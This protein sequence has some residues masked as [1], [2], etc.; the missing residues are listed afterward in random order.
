MAKGSESYRVLA[1]KYRPQSFED[2]VGQKHVTQT[3]ANAIAVDR[4]AH[5]YLF[6]G[7]RGVGKTT[8]ARIL[9][10]ALNCEKGPTAT[11]CNVCTPC[12]DITG[13][14]S[15]DVLEIDGASNR[16]INEVRELRENV[17]YA[18]SGMRYKVYIIDEVHMLTTEAFN[19][20]LKTLEEPP[21]H[22]IFVFA[23][24]EPF[25]VPGTILS[26]CQRFDFARIPAREITARLTEV[27]ARENRAIDELNKSAGE[28]TSHVEVTPEALA[29][30]ARRAAGGLRDALSLMDQ[31]ISAVDGPVDRAV[32][33]RT[34]GLVGSDFCFVLG[35]LLAAADA[36]GALRL[37]DEVYAKGADLGEVAESLT[38][39]LRDLLMLRIDPGLAAILDIPESEIPRYRAQAERF[40]RETLVELVDRAAETAVSL[41]RSDH[42]RLALELALAEM[43]QSAARVP[44]AEIARR[45]V[46]LEARLGGEAPASSPAVPRSTPAKTADAGPVARAAGT[47]PAPQAT[48]VPAAGGVWEAFLDALRP[49]SIR[50]WGTMHSTEFVGADADGALRVKAGSGAGLLTQVLR[51]PETQSLFREILSGLGVKTPEVRIEGAAKPVAAKPVEKPAAPK[52]VE[53]PAAPKAASK[54]AAKESAPPATEEPVTPAAKPEPPPAAKDTRSMGQLFN[55]EPMLQKALDM[56]DGEVLP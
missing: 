52:P 7:P 42:P 35:D 47:V 31:I 40:A 6:C 41:R 1:L 23:T 2:V 8:A 15:L 21:K 30:V 37:L 45:L 56:F 12:L 25:K 9:A 33:E 34:L 32:V 3:L 36:A 4:V 54:P 44:L 13:G 20:L 51:D 28:K 22:V 26:R 10:K 24:T 19:A 18:P 39:H 46:D 38:S 16:G 53:K 48:N 50:L 49:R 43:A 27:I 5:A 17:R 29:L 14:R 55:D 11:P